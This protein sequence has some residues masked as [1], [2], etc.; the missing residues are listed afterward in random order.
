MFFKSE[1][2]SCDIISVLNLEWEV[3]NAMSGLR[4]FHALS[5]RIK[6]N[7]KF[8]CQKNELLVKSGEIV[9]VPAN[10]KYTMQAYDEN[11]IVIHFLSKN[12][13]PDKIKKFSNR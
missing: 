5:Y 4:P 11:L 9:F 2:V 13:L 7:S 12:T 10:L 8:I 6:G 3:Q 1:N